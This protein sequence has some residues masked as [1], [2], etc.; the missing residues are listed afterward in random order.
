MPIKPTQDEYLLFIARQTAFLLCGSPR[1]LDLREVI[2]N[3][4][5]LV[6]RFPDGTEEGLLGLDATRAAD[7]AVKF[8]NG[9]GKGLIVSL[10]RRGNGRRPIRV[11]LRV[12]Y[13]STRKRSSCAGVKAVKDRDFVV[14]NSAEVLDMAQFNRLLLGE[15]VE[16]Q[17]RTQA[18]VRQST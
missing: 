13:G 16:M 2:L 14:G 9:T 7:L 1:C 4:R 18:G 6:G 3:E 15:V 17:R 10:E 12:E 11:P 5:S 8:K